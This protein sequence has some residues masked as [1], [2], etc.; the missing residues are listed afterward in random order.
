VPRLQHA[1]SGTRYAIRP[2]PPAY[3]RPDCPSTLKQGLIQP[4]RQPPEG[5]RALC[6]I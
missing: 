2:P 6:R 5:G 4:D 1:G 3:E